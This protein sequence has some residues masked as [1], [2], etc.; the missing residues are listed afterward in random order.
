MGGGGGQGAD[1]VQRLH[2]AGGVHRHARGLCHPGRGL[3]VDA[4]EH[5][6]A[7]DVGVDQAGDAGVG[8]AAGELERI[9]RGGLRPALDRDAAVARVEADHDVAGEARAGA[10]DEIRLAH[11]LGADDGP[12]DAGL[13]IGG[14][15]VAVADAAAD[16]QR[17]VGILARDRADHLGMPG[18]AGEGAVEVDQVQAP[19]T[20]RAPAAGGRDRVV[21][22]HRV[23]LHAPLAQAH[24][25]PALQVDGGDHQHRIDRAFI[26][27]PTQPA[28]GSDLRR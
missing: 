7:A 13:E 6:V 28:D 15:R 18:G 25:A 19:G 10:G 27:A 4:L 23:I 20:G 17:Q 3:D 11:R 21:G 8:E 9:V 5:A 1:V 14:D 16:L 12:G 2:A 22:E 26:A 24:A